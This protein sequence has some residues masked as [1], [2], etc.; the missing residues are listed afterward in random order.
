MPSSQ[1][2]KPVFP[3]ARWILLFLYVPSGNL[4]GPQS[5]MLDQLRKIGW[6]ILIVCAARSRDHVP[7]QVENYADALYWKALSGFDFS[8][9]SIGLNAISVASPAATVLV[10]NDSTFGPFG[11][12]RDLLEASPWDLV[13]ITGSHQLEK[14]IQSY[15]FLLRGVDSRRMR[16]LRTI[17]QLS[18]SFDDIVPV[19]F[20]LETQLAR[21]A[22]RHMTVG[23]LWF[24]P[25][26]GHDPSIDHGLALLGEGCPFLKRALLGKHR[27]SQDEVAVRR[28]LIERGVPAA[29]L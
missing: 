19:V 10:L 6:P 15:A 3:S 16:Q 27:G 8:G 12:L 9:Y 25:D 14:H 29:Y 17:F 11:N 26:D 5:F 24:G 23:S 2:V 22:A 21:V 20:C 18:Y 7:H 28:E 4:S 1:V 13:G